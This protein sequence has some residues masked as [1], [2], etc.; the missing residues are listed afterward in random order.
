MAHWHPTTHGDNRRG[1]RS[2]EYNVWLGMRRRCGDPK[3][4]SYADYGARGIVV[5]DRW[6][7]FANFLADMGRRPSAQHSIERRNNDLGYSPDN[8]I[9]ADRITQA[10]NRRPRTLRT[11]C[12]KGHS[13]SAEN[14]YLRPDGKRGCRNCRQSNMRDFYARKAGAQ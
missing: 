10:N 14:V 6:Q 13:L 3:C 8:C 2:G 11:H 9:W 5:C 1:A 4:K 7:T 12:A